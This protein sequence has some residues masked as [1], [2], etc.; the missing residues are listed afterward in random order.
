M[1][2]FKNRN[3]TGIWCIGLVLKAQA[4]GVSGSDEP[5][6]VAVKTVKATADENHFKA[7]ITELKIMAN[8]GKHMNIVNLL[9][10]CT[11]DLAKRSKC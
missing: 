2:N 5:T 3:S 9:G 4:I 11:R 6:T 8:L 7:L 1:F 10:A